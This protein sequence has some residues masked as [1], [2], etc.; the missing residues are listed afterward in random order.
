[1]TE[2]K[3][4]QVRELHEQGLSQRQ[5]AEKTGVPKSTVG[6]ILKAAQEAAAPPL[7]SIHATSQQWA[8][9]LNPWIRLIHQAAI[10]QIPECRGLSLEDFIYHC[11]DFAKRVFKLFPP[12]WAMQTEQVLD[13]SEPEGWDLPQVKAAAKILE[14]EAEN[15]G[16]LV[17]ASVRSAQS[18]AS[19]GESGESD[20]PGEHAPA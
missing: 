1:M 13:V 12:G 4:K 10:E 6:D 16:Q 14:R 18:D 3:E 7:P 2:G 20:Q 5:I 15:A 17:G 11:C 19:G 8:T 9:K